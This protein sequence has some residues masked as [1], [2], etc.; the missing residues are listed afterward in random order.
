M[1]CEWF[2]SYTTWADLFWKYIFT[3]RIVQS[4]VRFMWSHLGYAILPLMHHWTFCFHS[5][6][7]WPHV[8]AHKFNFPIEIMVSTAQQMQ[9]RKLAVR[10]RKRDT[11]NLKKKQAHYISMER[12]KDEGKN[13]SLYIY[14]LKRGFISFQISPFKAI[15]LYFVWL[16]TYNW[17]FC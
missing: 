8:R 12:S 9:C 6:S 1:N 11:H 14:F 5:S 10:K 16:L 13:G 17:S 3:I 7:F 15:I 4:Y 2:E